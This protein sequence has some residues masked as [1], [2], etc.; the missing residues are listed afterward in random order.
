M[1]R[2]V[3]NLLSTGLDV[4][5][6]VICLFMIIYLSFS[7]KRDK[8]AR[9]LLGSIISIIIFN[10]ADMSNWVSEG[11]EPH[12]KVPCLHILTFVY[13][14]VPP[15]IFET[16]IKFIEA[17]IAPKKVNPW[18]FRSSLILSGIYFVLVIITPFTGFFYYIDENN[19]YH[20][21][22]YN[23]FCVAFYAAY[24]ILITI[25]VIIYRKN[26]SKNAFLS[27]LSFSVFP[28]VL[29][30]IQMFFYGLSLVNV[31]LTIAILLIFLNMHMNLEYSFS[32]TVKKVREQRKKI[33]TLEE[34]IIF[35]FSNLVESREIEDDDGAQRTSLYVSLLAQKAMDDGYYPGILSRD[36]VRSLIK[37]SPMHDIGVITVSDS[38][39]KKPGPLTESERKEMQK[40]TVEGG[41]IIKKI[42]SG[43]DDEKTI[44]IA[45]EM[46]ELH[47]ERWD[48]KGYPYGLKG[49]AIPVSARIMAIADV[50]DALI[51]N[52]CY[53]ERV[54]SE[55]AFKIIEESAGQFD[56]IL[57]KEFLEI[58]NE[59]Q[60]VAPSY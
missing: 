27:F 22:T 25:M 7:V 51:S 48:G 13:Y 32:A 53:K 5:N 30:I 21:G 50:Y 24:F 52:R 17:N 3:T 23:Y 36:Y 57:V 47:H 2:A 11:L 19:F 9:Y 28:I 12:W 6:C 54:S 44:Q 39:M 58:K 15:F 20:R 35:S 38:I 37:A 40:H 4:Y 42:L 26:F 18:I 34:Q 59:I 31:G 55:E 16:I 43:Y 1:N 10:I 56:P 8:S 49:E 41:K 14:F 29:Q 46:A 60:M 33:F 45:K